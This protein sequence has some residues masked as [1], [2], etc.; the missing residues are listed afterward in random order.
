MRIVVMGVTGVGKSTVGARL[1]A[2]LGLPFVDADDLHDERAIAKMHEGAPLDDTDRA[3]WLAR[4]NVAL[5]DHAEGVII[6]ASSLTP[7]MRQ[8]MTDG[9]DGIRFVLLDGDPATIE[10]RLEGR[11]GHF[12][13]TALLASQFALLEPPPDAVILDAGRPPDE[14]V[15]QAVEALCNDGAG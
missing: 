7:A 15:A 1:A 11:I 5:R 10:S 13:G 9:I 14:L 8:A 6:A 12:A 2:A 4:L 3:P